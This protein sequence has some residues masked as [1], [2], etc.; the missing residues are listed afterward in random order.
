MKPHDR[1]LHVP[2]PTVQPISLAEI[3][4][5]HARA[6][7][8]IV[9]LVVSLDGLLPELAQLVSARLAEADIDQ[10]VA[11]VEVGLKLGRRVVGRPRVDGARQVGR[12]IPATELA[13]PL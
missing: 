5:G 8:A 13:G 2:Q 1:T 9:A 3:D 7:A 6:P 12:A 4:G 11:V 10:K